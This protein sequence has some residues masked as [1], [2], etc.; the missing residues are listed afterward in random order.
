MNISIIGQRRREAGMV[1][2]LVTLIMML[3]IILIV[4][5]FTQI[6]TQNRRQALDRQ[7]SNQA[8]FAAESGI[9]DV[10]AIVKT[11]SYSPTQ[12][13]KNTCGNTGSVA[14]G[15]LNGNLSSNAKYSCVLVRPFVD[16]I[17]LQ[18]LE[19]GRAKIVRLHAVD[20]GGSDALTNKLSFFWGPYTS[21]EKFSADTI[22]N[23]C[24]NTGDNWTAESYKCPFAVLRIDIVKIKGV[25]LTAQSLADNTSTLFIYPDGG[26]AWDTSGLL[27][28]DVL[29]NEVH[30][31]NNFWGSITT[32]KVLMF[33]SGCDVGW[34]FCSASIPLESNAVSSD[35]LLRI[36]PLQTSSIS[37]DITATDA[38]DASKTLLL[39][40][41]QIEI[42]STGKVGGNLRRVKVRANVNGFGTDDVPLGAIESQ[43]SICK[44]FSAQDASGSNFSSETCN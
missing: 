42:D 10:L 37:L 5:G 25:A 31:K 2:F 41:Q 30:A 16:K 21:D 7:L 19:A 32:G 4:I 40:D 33:G 35:Y 24:T 20:S 38:N 8:Y 1:S 39:A 26:F 15:T 11:G 23:T 18:K 12:L 29:K 9:N 34:Q 3:V 17:Q 27:E 22:Q 14:Y 36:T 13:V 43:K 44:T 6:S 28:G